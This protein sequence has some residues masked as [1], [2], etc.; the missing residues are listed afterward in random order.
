MSIEVKGVTKRFGDFVA[1][2]DVNVSIPT[3]QLTA[4]LGPSGGGK[5]T[6][7][8]V[9]AGLES[10][11]SGTIEIEGVDAT[12]LAPQK[13]NVGFVFQHYAAFKH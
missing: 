13:R 11:D 6:L 2:E 4:L 7:L 10:A 1:L 12:R 3:G 8:R 5:S 9:I